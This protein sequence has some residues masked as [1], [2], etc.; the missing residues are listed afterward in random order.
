MKTKI[1]MTILSLSF[2]F[3][4][5][6]GG[7]GGGG[8]AGGPQVKVSLA[9]A[10]TTDYRAVYVTVGEV[11]IQKEGDTAWTALSSTKK[12]VNLLRLVNGVREQLALTGIES[13]HYTQLRLILT[14]IPDDTLNIL[15]VKH[16]YANYFID[17]SNSSVELKVPSGFQTGIKIVQGF[18]ISSSGTTELI[19]DFDVVRSIVRAGKSSQ[20][21]LKPTIKMLTTVE[22]SI[23][24]GK[25]DMEGVLVSAQVYNGSGSRPGGQSAGGGFNRQQ[26]RRQLCALSETRVLYPGRI[27]GRACRLF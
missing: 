12:T 19:L 2:L 11:A 25:V 5:A 1:W 10:T 20:W 7:G 13:G 16:P 8:V 26:C 6:C 27:Q 24:Q 23:I 22:A 21:L 3:M 14:D 18:D 15:S 17:Q 9:D 4:A